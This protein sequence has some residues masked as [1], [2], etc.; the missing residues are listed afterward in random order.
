[1]I[2][3]THQNVGTQGVSPSW[4]APRR[5]ESVNYEG[6]IIA[7]A[8]AYI[9]HRMSNE[10]CPS[11]QGHPQQDAARWLCPFDLMVYVEVVVCVLRVKV[12]YEILNL[13]EARIVTHL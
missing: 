9:R 11:L 3:S 7:L 1:M 6:P 2:S 10:Q 5:E 13:G 12:R 4:I 8:T